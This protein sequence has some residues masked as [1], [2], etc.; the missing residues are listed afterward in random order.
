MSRGSCQGAIEA[1]DLSTGR[2]RFEFFGQLYIR[3]Y[4]CMKHV[5]MCPTSCGSGESQRGQCVFSLFF[6][7]FFFSGEEACKT[8]SIPTTCKGLLLHAYWEDTEDPNASGMLR[9]QPMARWSR[10]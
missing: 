9:F 1:T 2:R 7:F 3:M 8:G 4:K 5:R 6:S 10:P